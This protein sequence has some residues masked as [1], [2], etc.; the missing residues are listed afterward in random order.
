MESTTGTP[1]WRPAPRGAL[2]ARRLLQ[3]GSPT[4][5]VRVPS[6]RRAAGRRGGRRERRRPGARGA[7]AE[8]R[9]D[10]APTARAA[11]ARGSRGGGPGWAGSLAG[12]GA[13]RAREGAGGAGAGR[14]RER[15]VKERAGEDARDRGERARERKRATW[16]QP[17]FSPRFGKGPARSQV[18]AARGFHGD[19]DPSEDVGF[20]GSFTTRSP[21]PRR[22]G[23]PTAPHSTREGVC[24][25]PVPLHVLQEAQ[26]SKVHAR[27]QLRTSSG[28]SSLVRETVGPSRAHRS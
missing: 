3:Q 5:G 6:A 12:A 18:E 11:R 22:H 1:A 27:D 23:A 25:D 14:G 2:A 13:G 21:T 8:A 10:G 20:D 15:P 19:D 17:Y 9:D 24:R 28:S 7:R 16:S 4:S 26:V